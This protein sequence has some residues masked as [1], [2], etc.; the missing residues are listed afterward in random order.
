MRRREFIG[1]LGG[2]AACPFAAR[3]QQAAMPVIGFLN[4]T[5]PSGYPHVIAAFH[6]GLAEAGYVE[7][8]NVRI[9]YRWAQNESRRVP[10]L[11]AELVRLKVN[12]IAATGGDVGALAAKAAT[13]DIPIVFNSSGDPVRTG[14]VQS[15]N[16]PGG[17]LTGVSRIGSDILPKR[18]ELLAEVVPNADIIAFLI[19]PT[20]RTL[21]ARIADVEAAAHK[22][23]RQIV[24]LRASTDAELETLFA[25]A[26]RS[27]ARALLAINDGF[28]NTRSAKMGVLS[29]RNSIPSIYQNREFAEAG[30][31][32]SY[33]A[34]LADAYR[35]VG[36]YTGRIL[37]G[38]KP[39]DLP[40]QQQT[41]V[42]LCINLKTAKALGLTIPLPLLGRADEVIE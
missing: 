19:N 25:S 1:I 3:A 10:E 40:V 16:R 27:R 36:N 6:Q 41:K 7:G 4:P 38:E 24:V 35:L 39:A 14:L 42:D 15:L 9:E 20:A 26:G 28:F 22:L 18:L 17:N 5:S 2:V 31:L 8:R 33:G 34:S 23:G 37:K 12:V 11:A 21:E 29:L 13:Q 32:M 30:G